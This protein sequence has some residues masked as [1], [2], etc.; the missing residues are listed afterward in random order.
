MLL[1][2]HTTINYENHILNS[3]TLKSDSV[4]LAW[5]FTSSP[6][7]IGTHVATAQ[8]NVFTLEEKHKCG[9]GKKEKRYP[10][11]RIYT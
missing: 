9:K 4:N 8:E 3:C 6:G 11:T 1:E 10:Y 7:I 2:P 5:L